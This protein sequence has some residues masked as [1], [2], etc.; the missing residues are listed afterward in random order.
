MSRTSQRIAVSAL[1]LSLVGGG[2]LVTAGAASAATID[3]VAKPMGACDAG[4][5]YSVQSRGADQFI[6]TGPVQ[7]ARNESAFPASFTFSSETS[8]TVGTTI[9]GELNVGIEAAI[10]DIGATLGIAATVERTTTYGE[11]AVVTVSPQSMGYGQHGVFQA[12]VSGMS[13]YRT[14]SCEV[15]QTVFNTIDVPFMQ[16][17]KVW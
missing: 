11:S 13:Q 17:Y 7:A 2:S 8:G 3:D 16:G 15:T 5:Y 1:A 14:P 12:R 4:W 6:P 9:S 10:A